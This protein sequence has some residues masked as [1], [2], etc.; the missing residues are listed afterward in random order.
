M[1]NP[2]SAHGKARHHLKTSAT[3]MMASLMLVACHG[4]SASKGQGDGRSVADSGPADVSSDGQ[5]VDADP[6]EERDAAAEEDAVEIVSPFDGIDPRIDGPFA[7]SHVIRK[8]TVGGREL[9]VSVWG[10]TEATA[11]SV[12]LDALVA[13]ER[14][15]DMRALLL[16]AP[17]GCPT[18]TLDVALD[19]ELA[20]GRWPLVLYSH[21]HECLG[22]SGATLARRLATWGHVVLAPDHTGNTLWDARDGTNVVLSAEFLEVRGA[23]IMGLMDAVEAGRAPFEDLA[24]HINMDVVGVTGHSFGSVTAGWVTQRDARVD[25]AVGIAAPMENILLP[26]VTVAEITAP[27][28][29]MVAREDNSIFEIGNRF[30]RE[31]YDALGGPAVKVEFGDAGHWSVSDLCGLVQAFMAGC[32]DDERQTDGTPFTYLDPDLGRAATATWGVALFGA[33]L[34]NDA[35]A[36]EWLSTAPADDVAVEVTRRGF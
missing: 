26:G 24:A 18:E 20:Q 10:P 35:A 2:P 14:A 1:A 15:E 5:D 12:A 9:S 8:A 29:L 17:E 31:N 16:E 34:H 13:P 33:V 30:I 6:S 27:T 22:A 32:G 7:A 21:C 19:A 4:E 11:T 3:M 23:D 36:L 28:L 25:A